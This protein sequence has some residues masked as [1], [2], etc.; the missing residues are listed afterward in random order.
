MCCS[1]ISNSK[2]MTL[3]ISYTHRNKSSA[4]GALY[5]DDRV[6]SG[7]GQKGN[8]NK[9]ADKISK[10]SSRFFIGTIGLEV[11]KWAIDYAIAAFEQYDSPDY[12][13]DKIEE[14]SKHLES[15]FKYIFSQW[16]NNDAYYVPE[17]ENCLSALILLDTKDKRVYYSETIKV[18]GSEEIKVK[19]NSM[20]DGVHAFFLRD[21]KLVLDF[22]SVFD[23]IKPLRSLKYNLFLE[24][25]KKIT[26]NLNNEFGD[27]FSESGSYK[28]L[29]SGKGSYSFYR[30]AFESYKE[31]FDN[32]FLKY[33]E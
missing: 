24:H 23:H 8:A 27:E 17:Q 32:N 31:F 15:G 25:V 21:D 28:I 6:G 12:H 26:K 7:N 2:E 16:R 9:K 4:I 19:F 5:A 1:S 29:V 11:T 10:L 22:L 33:K 3:I 20:D 30:S 13:F 18:W 14:L